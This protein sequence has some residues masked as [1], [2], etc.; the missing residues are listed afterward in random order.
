[1]GTGGDRKGEALRRIGCLNGDTDR[2]RQD[3]FG[4]GRFLD[5][6]DLIQV[7]YEMVRRARVEG[8]TVTAAAAAFGSSRPTFYHAESAIFTGGV[9]ALIPAKPGPRRPHKL[10]EEVVDFLVELL[11][12]DPSQSSR[13][14]APAV[15]ERFGVQVHPRSIER[16]LARLSGRGPQ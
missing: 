11:A 1:M 13:D 4:V 7:K 16:A 8:Q 6:R 15:R 14:L 2:V 12:S 10:G 3:G 5:P 9:G